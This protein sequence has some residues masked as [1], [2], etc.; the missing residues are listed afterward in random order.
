VFGVAGYTFLGHPDGRLLDSVALRLE[1]ARVIR[2]VR[3]DAII[4]SDPQFF[5]SGWYLNHP[6]HRAAGAVT[7]AAVMPLA[8]TLL[9]APELIQEDL[10]PHDVGEVYLAI[11]AKPTLY[12][13]LGE[14]DFERKAAA[15]GR[16]TSQ[17]GNWDFKTLMRQ[18]AEQVGAEAR[19][20]GVACDMAEAFVY[21]N[22][23]RP[24]ADEMV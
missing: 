8:N 14:G 13:P 11:P 19:A 21:V 18:F 4:T 6:D 12:V 15:M 23:R 7:T 10:A 1:V 20:A 17:V 3:P 2:R 9:A 16:H 24:A 22:L 5:Y